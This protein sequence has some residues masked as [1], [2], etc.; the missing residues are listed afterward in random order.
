[1]KIL[2]FILPFIF[3]GP[4]Y[5]QQNDGATN[6]NVFVGAGYPEMFHGG[7][8]VDHKQ[9]HFDASSGTTFREKEFT[10][11]GNAALHLGKKRSEFSAQKPWYTS[12]GMSYVQ[13]TELGSNDSTNVSIVTPGSSTE[14]QQG[15][16][17]IQALGKRTY[18]NGRFG[19]D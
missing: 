10:L 18:I 7:I 6:V 2:A 5:C 9:W 3:V 15:T 16:Q 17:E 12:L 4:A 11:N 1:M 14:T 8:R 13:W 19:R